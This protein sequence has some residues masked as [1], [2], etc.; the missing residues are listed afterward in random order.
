MGYQEKNWYCGDK[1]LEKIAKD[2]DKQAEEIAK[3]VI[4][5]CW[6]HCDLG[7]NRIEVMAFDDMSDTLQAVDLEQVI[8]ERLDLLDPPE[9]LRFL[10]ILQRITEKVCAETLPQKM[11]KKRFKS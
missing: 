8:T 11:T 1:F 6:L 9:Q 3:H 5:E 10:K 2:I 7:K 4:K